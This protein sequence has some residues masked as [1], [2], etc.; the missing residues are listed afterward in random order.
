MQSNT[1]LRLSIIIPAFNE[2]DSII[3]V[4][5]AVLKHTVEGVTYEVIVIDD[6][7]TDGTRTKLKDNA[8]L[9]HQLI[10]MERNS[11]KGAAVKAGLARASGDY[12]LFQDADFEYDPAD[13]VKL[14]SPV[15]RFNAD[16]VMG[17]RLSAPPIT[18][19]YYFWNKVASK[20]LTWLF[21]VRFNVAFT[22]IFSCYL[23]YR[24][25]LL[26]PEELI[27]SGWEQHVE[28]L[29]LIVP[30]AK[31]MYEV[32]VSYYGR[33]YDEGKKIRFYH[34]FPM[35]RTILFR[36]LGQART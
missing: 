21:N 8:H 17:S 20:T 13:Y 16:I 2:A 7:S 10:L 23:L 14:L 3:E 18:R 1:L 9:Y 29:T 26:K 32:P 22:D 19:V 25:S 31:R 5:Q 24:R 12:I 6:G 33:S 34:V 4:L 27:T 35:L 15:T 30:R 28:I 11:G 36:A